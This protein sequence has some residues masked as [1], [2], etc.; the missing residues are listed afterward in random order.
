MYFKE[1]HNIKEKL[2]HK[3]IEYLKNDICSFIGYIKIENL[4]CKIYAMA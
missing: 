3:T 4:L 2:E 1:N